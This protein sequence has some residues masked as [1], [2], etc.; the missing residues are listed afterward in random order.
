MTLDRARAEALDAADALASF[1]DRFVVSDPGLIYLDGN[2]LGRLPKATP[3]RLREV[4]DEEWGGGL[5]RS[6]EQW[7]DLPTRVGDQIGE[8]LLGA[9]PGEVVVSDSTTV[10]LYKLT[11]A[12]CDARPG[13]SV[14]VTDD[15]NF[16]TDRYVFDGI[17]QARGLIACTHAGLKRGT[18]SG[19]E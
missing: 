1:R 11:I 6:W 5:I 17:A 15:D 2:S 8:H 13:R 18:R 9:R 16:A 19:L 14:I 12:A 4:L 3:A 7:I 10:N